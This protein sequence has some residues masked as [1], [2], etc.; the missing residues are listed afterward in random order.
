MANQDGRDT[1]LFRADGPAKR[2][3]ITAV[4]PCIPAD[5]S[6]HLMTCYAHLGQHS[7]CSLQWYH[8]TRPAKPEEYADLKAELEAKPYEYRLDVRQR[9]TSDMHE[10]RRSE[11]RR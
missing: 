3:N 10:V 8:T 11:A 1:V 4:F 5:D 7:G 2:P 6:G 9:I